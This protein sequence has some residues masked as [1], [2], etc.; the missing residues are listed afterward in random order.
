[1]LRFKPL[2]LSIAQ[3]VLRMKVRHPQFEVHWK[4]SVATWRGEI[5]PTVLSET[6][7]VQIIYRLPNRPVITSLR[8]TLCCRPGAQ[9]IPHTYIGNSLCLYYPKYH[10]WT[11][12]DFIAETVVPWASLWLF[13]YEVWHATGVWFGAGVAH[14]PKKTDRDQSSAPEPKR[15]GT[16]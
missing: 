12:R 5:Q 13:Y 6:Y 10:E 7:R 4:D 1:M 9:R 11:P 8:P 2:R 14:L 16:V 3:Q 15:A